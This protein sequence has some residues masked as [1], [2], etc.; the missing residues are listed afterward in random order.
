M[1]GLFVRFSWKL[2]SIQK[3]KSRVAPDSLVSISLPDEIIQTN[4][5]AFSVRMFNEGQ[6]IIIVKMELSSTQ[7]G[8][9]CTFIIVP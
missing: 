2:K 6:C 1:F 5:V 4:S 8:K 3:C 7:M 9:H